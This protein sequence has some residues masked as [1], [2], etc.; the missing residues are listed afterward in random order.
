[1]LNA[2]V[3]VGEECTGVCSNVKTE[4]EERKYLESLH[5]FKILFSI[6]EKK[7]TKKNSTPFAI[8]TYSSVQQKEKKKLKS[9]GL[10]LPSFLSILFDIITIENIDLS[11]GGSLKL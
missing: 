6:T 4:S 10:P 9:I 2:A 3:S 5:P 11:L 8:Q 1:M 7:T